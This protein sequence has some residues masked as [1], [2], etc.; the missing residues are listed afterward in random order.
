M[1]VSV[2][3]FLLGALTVVGAEALG[4]VILIR[5][6]NRKLAR[7]VARSKIVR[8]QS[9]PGNIDPS[10]RRKQAGL[11]LGS[12]CRK[13]PK[14]FSFGQSFETAKGKKR[15]LGGYTYKEICKIE[16]SFSHFNRIRCFSHRN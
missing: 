5:W 10:S 14:S 11:C 15:D 7:E 1:W 13:N 9:S 3:V 2:I 12:R 4:A 16:G 8:E 6:L